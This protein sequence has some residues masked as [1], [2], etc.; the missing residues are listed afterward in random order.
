MHGNL[1]TLVQDSGAGELWAFLMALHF[2]LPPVV[3]VTDYQH[4]ID[5]IAEGREACTA[6]N[7]AHADI[8]RQIWIAIDDFGLEYVTL[9]KVKAHLSLASV[10]DGSAQ[11]TWQ[12][13]HG[14]RVADL[15]AKLGAACHP[16]QAGMK[17]ILETSRSLVTYVAKW[18]GTLGAFLVG[19]SSPDVQPTEPKVPIMLLYG[20]T[21]S[22]Q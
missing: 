6:A 2:S 15:H 16:A 19:L 1:P 22:F 10:Q 18:L 13:W 14:N 12:D 5:G 8:W 3:V 20:G 7:R 4:L 9:Q 21:T 17:E 11:V